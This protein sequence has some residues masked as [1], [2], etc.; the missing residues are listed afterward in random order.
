[1]KTWV[2]QH[3]YEYIKLTKSNGQKKAFR[4][5]R[6]VAEHFVDGD[7]T[8]QVDHIDR[9]RLNNHASN[10]RWSSIEENLSNRGDTNFIHNCICKCGLEVS[11][12][13]KLGVE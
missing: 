8:L 13:R 7:K 3:G 12:V 5:H 10:L 6:L 9:N 2:N 4:V 11:Y 1:M